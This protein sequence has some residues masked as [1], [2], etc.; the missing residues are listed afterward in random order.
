MEYAE[1]AERRAVIQ[2]LEYLLDQDV[3]KKN[4]IE[5]MS[6]HFSR[7]DNIFNSYMKSK[8]L[9]FRGWL[10]Y[11]AREVHSEHVHTFPRISFE[12]CKDEL[13]LAAKKTSIELV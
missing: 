8:K 10:E 1:S 6:D 2:I 12:E 7:L 5:G 13:C 4:S 11:W 9:E 3:L